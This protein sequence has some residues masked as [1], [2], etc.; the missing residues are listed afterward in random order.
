M[1]YETNDTHN[2][3]LFTYVLENTQSK[4]VRVE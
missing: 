2:L 4:T 1:K 3:I